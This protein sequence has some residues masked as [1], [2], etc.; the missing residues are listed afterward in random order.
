LI[1]SKTMPIIP[2]SRGPMSRAKT[3][4][5]ANWISRPTVFWLAAQMMLLTTSLVVVFDE[6]VWDG[7]SN[8]GIAFFAH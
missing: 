1:D 8:S 2:I 3:T 4:N 7:T 5:I 6:S